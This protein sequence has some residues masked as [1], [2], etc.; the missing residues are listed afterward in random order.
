MTIVQ[1]VAPTAVTDDPQSALTLSGLTKKYA[2]E[3]VVNDVSL[4]VRQ[5]DFLGLLGPNGAGK[6]TL[7]SVIS[8]LIPSDS[9]TY[10]LFGMES[11]RNLS[12]IKKLL[13]VVPQDL[14]VYPELNAHDNLIFF[15]SMY[16]LR[17]KELRGRVDD[18][19]RR[20]GLADRGKKP[21]VGKFSGGQKR[22]LNIAAALLHR[23]KVLIL[24]E[25]TVGVDPQS[26]NY[27]FDTLRELND[28]GMTIVYVTHYMEEVEALCNEVAIMDHGRVIERG[29]LTNILNTHGTSVI[30]LKLS[31]SESTAA[32]AFLTGQPDL[33][34]RENNG[35]LE[36]SSKQLND[37]TTALTTIL[38]T[39]APHPDECQI[40]PPSLETVFITLTGKTLRDE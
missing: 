32:H 14:A 10:S 27:I 3:T 4:T 33:T 6:T 19:L 37:A 26:R 17:G 20:V 22:R 39:I 25:P 13:G 40:L 24:D 8:G 2:G 7:I 15:G 29:A 23:P 9:G 18:A 16:G 5:G 30:R 21:T 38:S 28:A 36:I 1:E 11:R 31:E 35:Y 12:Q 34:W